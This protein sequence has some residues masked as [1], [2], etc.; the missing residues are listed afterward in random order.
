MIDR[1]SSWRLDSTM[2]WLAL[3]TVV[4]VGLA[5]SSNGGSNNDAGAGGTGGSG[6]KTCIDI[7]RCT[8]EAACTNEACVTMCK[9]GASA[10]VIADFDALEA[11]TT[12]TALCTR[13]GAN[14]QT[15][16]CEA[17]CMEPLICGQQVDDCLANPLAVDQVCD[18][19]F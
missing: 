12:T 6:P 3:A 14:Y 10:D 4:A 8:V 15:C 18:I 11:C 9:M 17:Q 1:P 19:C 2:R 5:C 16:F 7:R 13:G